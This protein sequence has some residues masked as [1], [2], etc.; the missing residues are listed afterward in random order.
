MVTFL[1][2]DRAPAGNSAA[3]PALFAGWGGNG[4]DEDVFFRP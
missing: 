1:H 4:D 2:A 3:D